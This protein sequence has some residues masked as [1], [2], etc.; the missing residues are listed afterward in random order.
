MSKFGVASFEERQQIENNYMKEVIDYVLSRSDTVKV[1]V[2]DVPLQKRDDVDL[3][4]HKTNSSVSTIEVK[5]DAQAH[6]TGNFA[7]ETISQELKATPGC[8][9]R[10]KSNYFYYYWAGSADLW[11]ME[12]ERMQRWFVDEMTKTPKRFRIVETATQL[13]NGRIYTS[14][15]RLVPLKD[16]QNGLGENLHHKK[17]RENND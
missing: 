6:K 4:W 7:F 10:T 12:T 14:I 9:L 8:I 5:I 11:R 1:D 2:A 16:L 15:C 3:I 13:D 17:L